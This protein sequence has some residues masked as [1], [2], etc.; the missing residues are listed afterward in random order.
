[1]SQFTVLGESGYTRPCLVALDMVL[2]GPLDP[3]QA[4]VLTK[5]GNE[6]LIVLWECGEWPF[7]GIIIPTGFASG[8]SGEGA[9]GFSLALCMLHEQKIPLDHLEV[10]PAIFDSID[11]GRF[12]ETWQERIRDSAS[13]CKMPIPGWIFVNHWE[14]TGNHGLWRVQRWRGTGTM[15]TKFAEAV[16]DFSSVVGNKLYQACVLVKRSA[17]PEIYQQVGLLLRDGWIEFSHGIRAKVGELPGQP[18]K[19]DVKAVVRALHLDEFVTKKA[20]RAYN[21]TN[22]LQHDRKA[23]PDKA[24]ACF[25]DSVMAMAKIISARFPDERDSHKDDLTRPNGAHHTP[26]GLEHGRTTR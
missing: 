11:G 15:W 4:T 16:D 20:E 2:S 8:Y 6:H 7:E 18:G 13:A 5:D 17:Q 14:L 19:N 3:E 24:R 10:R 1:M 22:A 9:R 26:E 25:T 23:N 21:S 12:P